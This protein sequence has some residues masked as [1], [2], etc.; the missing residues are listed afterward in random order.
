MTLE[1]ALIYLALFVIGSAV[2]IPFGSW[3]NSK[4]L[5]RTWK[6]EIDKAKKEIAESEEYKMAV[7]LMRNLNELLKSEEARK[8]FAQLTELIVQLIGDEESN[9]N[10]E[11]VLRLPKKSSAALERRLG[12]GESPKR[13][14]G[15]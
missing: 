12:G 5:T 9:E 4:L 2:G 14:T 11:S 3:L 8:F 10:N 15:E 7:E 1:E 6:S 13:Q